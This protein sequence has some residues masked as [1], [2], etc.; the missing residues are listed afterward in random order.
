M[1]PRYV[2]ERLRS[3]LVCFTLQL[4]DEGIEAMIGGLALVIVFDEESGALY[5]LDM[6]DPGKPRVVIRSESR[7][8]FV[9]CCLAVA[10]AKCASVKTGQTGLE[11]KRTK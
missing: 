2:F 7:L 6:L 1:T 3:W 4:T 10:Q 5:L 11:Q 9:C 8:E